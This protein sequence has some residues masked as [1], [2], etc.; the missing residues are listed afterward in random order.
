MRTVLVVLAAIAVILAAVLLL[1]ELRWRAATA[2]AVAR[3]RG[4]TGGARVPLAA[5]VA[6]LLPQGRQ[7]YWRGRLVAVSSGG[8]TN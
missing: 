8:S 5:E 4:T 2:E 7:T 6:W 3:L 1:A